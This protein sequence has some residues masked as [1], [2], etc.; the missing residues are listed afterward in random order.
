MFKDRLKKIFNPKSLVGLVLILLVI[1][2]VPQTA[3]AA[4]VESVVLQ[5][6][7]HVIAFFVSVLGQLLAVVINVLV[8]VA[9]YNGFISAPP[10]NVGWTIVRDLCNMFFVLILLIIAFATILH[11]PDYGIKQ[12]LKRVII[13]AILI[14]FSKMICGL[15][16]DFAQVVMLTFVNGFKDIGG[17]NMIT[18]LG[19]NQ[20]LALDQ[21]SISDPAKKADFWNVVGSY[22]LAWI[23][24][25]IM[26]VVMVALLGTLIFRI[27]MIWIY[28]ILSPLAYLGAVVPATKNIWSTWWKQFG[29]NVIT[30]PLLAF[31]IWLSLATLGQF[32]D[33]D[34]NAFLT[35][36]GFNVPDAGSAPEVGSTPVGTSAHMMRLGVS[37][38]LLIGGL[39]VSKSFGGAIGGAAAAS[40]SKM[41]SGGAGWMKKKSL[42]LAK[43]GAVATVKGTGRAAWATTKAGGRVGLGLAKTVDYKAAQGLHAV[44]RGLGL[45]QGEYKGGTGW[46]TRGAEGAKN[47]FNKAT[48]LK[49][50]RAA[51]NMKSAAATTAG[52]HYDEHGVK[53]SYDSNRK[54]FVSPDGKASNVKPINPNSVVQKFIQFM[55]G[56]ATGIAKD[57]AQVE[58][59][60]KELE[61]LAKPYKDRSSEEIHSLMQAT[62]DKQKLKGMQFALADKSDYKNLKD[63]NGQDTFAQDTFNKGKELFASD[64]TQLK[65]FMESA[66]KKQAILAFDLSNKD[67]KEAL[68]QAIK[69]NK[70]KLED[71]TFAGLEL[72]PNKNVNAAADKNK[73]ADFT[74]AFRTALHKER[75]SSTINKIDKDGDPK[76]ADQLSQALEELAHRKDEDR[77]HASGNL[78]DAETRLGVATRNFQANPTPTNANMVTTFA[79]ERDAFTKERDDHAK[80]LTNLRADSLTLDLK[81]DAIKAF[82][83]RQGQY[84]KDDFEKYAS[85]ASAKQLGSINSDSLAGNPQALEAL[86][87]VVSHER[88]KTLERSGNN[89]DLAKV[90]AAE[91]LKNYDPDSE[92][93]VNI[94]NDLDANL[95]EATINKTIKKILEKA[96]TAGAI[97]L[98]SASA[99]N[100][101]DNTLNGLKNLSRNAGVAP[102]QADLEN[103]LRT[104]GKI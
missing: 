79:A 57:A 104:L 49:S 45:A 46:G 98:G 59:S 54:A 37:L 31:F 17:G 5:I 83:N 1:L 36:N 3:R 39:M 87:N 99:S 53:Y 103:Y 90:I 7:G 92:K 4:S 71:Q 11:L 24:V 63:T 55:H 64:P 88:L 95:G 72:D 81:G 27:V 35:D 69:K 2:A 41:L 10:V 74:E 18:L 16:V 40:A 22:F 77:D 73:L 29:Q 44:G 82:S 48:K 75:W 21:G 84:D 50:E 66:Q 51:R 86:A 26:L 58:K 38:A 89:S 76:A 52:Y 94:Y 6:I 68:E 20:L 43:R 19:M 33:S 91:K 34:N 70:I 62:T 12:L 13:F 65:T 101:N 23:Y 61:E 42:G 96:G 47:I 8:E 78:L 100:L 60:K 32:T 28:V 85:K 67:Q 9:Q 25:I 80:D 97:K 93:I 14:N 30:G 56:S 102:S 15:V